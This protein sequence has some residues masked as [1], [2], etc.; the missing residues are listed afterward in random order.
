MVVI[1]FPHFHVNT[2]TRV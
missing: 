1:W 2:I